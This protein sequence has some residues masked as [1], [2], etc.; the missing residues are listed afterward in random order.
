MKVRLSSVSSAPTT[1]D[2]SDTA[3]R[4]RGRL[5]SAAE[6]H[7]PLRYWIGEKPLLKRSVIT[8]EGDAND[9][10]PELQGWLTKEQ[11]VQTLG[12]KKSGVKRKRAGSNSVPPRATNKRR[13]A[14]DDDEE[15]YKGWDDE[16]EASCIAVKWSA[17][18]STEEEELRRKTSVLLGRIWSRG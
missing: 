14:D 15:D 11:S 18:G 2:W 3:A 9:V 16:T 1:A 13:A 12:Q 17:S 10:V 5:R 4:T 8:D 7:A 6:R